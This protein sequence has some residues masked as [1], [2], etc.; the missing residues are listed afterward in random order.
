LLIVAILL[1]ASPLHAYPEPPGD[2]ENAEPTSTDVTV[3]TAPH[4]ETM[5]ERFEHFLI[6]GLGWFAPKIIGSVAST[7]VLFGAQA[8]LGALGM[9]STTAY[10]ASMGLSLGA[11]KIINRAGEI[12]YQMLIGEPEPKEDHVEEVEPE[13]KPEPQP[14]TKTQPQPQT[15]TRRKRKRKNRHRNRRKSP[16]AKKNLPT[17]DPGKNILPG[18]RILVPTAP[19]SDKDIKVVPPT[20]GFNKA[21]TSC[22]KSFA[23][24]VGYVWPA[25]C[26]AAGVLAQYEVGS[27]V[28]TILTQGLHMA[29]SS[30]G[31]SMVTD[32]LA[33]LANA[34]ASELMGTAGD[35]IEISRAQSAP[36]LAQ[37]KK[38]GNH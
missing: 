8:E 9:D 35:K 38:G 18:E 13:A 3:P 19:P 2:G 26:Q 24:S 5:V 16:I 30:F 7:A 31:A 23:E 22:T 10:Y 28:R 14:Q 15:Q 34:E 17:Q 37:S 27:I 36:K 21:P 4:E 33:T 20:P 32:A 6:N 11:Y 29:A 12:V 1:V 25:L